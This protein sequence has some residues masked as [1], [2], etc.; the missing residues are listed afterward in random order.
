MRLGIDDVYR[1]KIR[2]PYRRST[3]RRLIKQIT[4]LVSR[5]PIRS[6]QR[7]FDILAACAMIEE[8][9][10]YVSPTVERRLLFDVVAKLAAAQAALDAL[11]QYTGLIAIDALPASYGLRAEALP[12]ITDI[13]KRATKMADK[14][15][16]SAAMVLLLKGTPLPSKSGCRR[17]R[18]L[19]FEGFKQATKKQMKAV[20]NDMAA[21][22]FQWGTGR[23]LIGRAFEKACTKALSANDCLIDYSA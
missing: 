18:R 14:T 1:R 19:S 4:D 23:A 20:T 12:A 8:M 13:A 15:T 5:N 7:Q 10:G 16:G 9:P 6:M 17:A 3:R 21:L 11:P 22:L 2:T